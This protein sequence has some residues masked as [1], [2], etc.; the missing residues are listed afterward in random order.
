MLGMR[1][2]VTSLPNFAPQYDLDLMKLLERRDWEGAMAKMEEFV[3]PLY[4][5][6]GN[7]HGNGA[8]GEGSR[9]IR[10]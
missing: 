2:H 1:G 6:F 3:V 7:A 9:W 10:S 5:S 8:H 4:R